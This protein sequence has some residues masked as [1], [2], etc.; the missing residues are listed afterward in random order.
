MSFFS[1]RLPINRCALLFIS[2]F[3][4]VSAQVSFSQVHINELLTSTSETLQDGTPLE[5]I[6]LHNAG[7]TSVDLTGYSLSD[8]LLIPYK[9]L[10]PSVTLQPDEYLLIYAT[11]LN[12]YNQDEYHTNFR[13]DRDGETISLTAPNGVLEDRVS[14]PVQQRDISYGRDPQT[15]TLWRFFSPPSPGEANSPNGLTGFTQPEAAS[16]Q[17]GRYDSGFSLQLLPSNP[18]ADIRYTLDGSDPTQTSALYNNPISINQTTV[19]RT[20]SYLDGYLPSDI[21]SRSYIIRESI[22][23]PILSLSTDPDNLWDSRTGIYANATASGDAWERPVHMEYFA[24]MGTLLSSEDAGIRMHGGASRNRAEKK[25]FRLY[26][27]SDYGPGRLDAPIIPDALDAKPFD[28]LVLRAGYNDS[29]IHWSPVERDLTTYVYDQL[30]R[31]LSGD[32]GAPYS[33]GD[34][35]DLY[36]NGE[37]WGFYNISERVEAD[38][39]EP[40]YGTDEWIVV[41]DEETAEGDPRAWS[42]LRSF[43]QR[44]NF[45]DDDDYLQIQQMVDLEQLTDYYILNIWVSNT[46]WPTKNFYAAREAHEN[47]LWRFIIWDIEWSFGAGGLM[48]DIS[49]N[50]FQNARGNSGT[51]GTMLNRLLRRDEYQQYFLDRLEYNLST[52][53]SEEHVNQRFDELLARVR[54]FMPRESERWDPSRNLETFDSAIAAGKN[55]IDKRTDIVRNHI[56]GYLN[57]PTPTPTPVG[58]QPTPT[59]GGPPTATPTPSPTNPP[60]PTPT[61]TIPIVANLGIFDGNSDIGNVDADGQASY[62][63]ETDLYRVSGSGA[64]VWG[65]EDEFHFVFKQVEGP[66]VFDA[67]TDAINHGSNDWAKVMLMARNSLDPGAENFAIRIR[68]SIMEIS[69]QWRFTQGDTSFSTPGDDRVPSNRHDGRLRIVRENDLFQSYYFDTVD[70]EWVLIDEVSIPMN[71]TIYV[72]FA[73]TSHEDGSLAE[74]VY[75]SVRLEYDAPVSDWIMY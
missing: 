35:A 37:Y 49:A 25:S 54:A 7:D 1:L 51:L 2:I 50:A 3:L 21:T 9:W 16:H 73:V 41:K 53:L 13:L 55:F 60:V 39:F 19:I 22:N 48:G 40:F 12:L 4:T 70:A 6:E 27:R 42:T 56:Y 63:S 33:R 44:A 29:W 5:W 38:M 52:V 66:F 58:N 62:V 64:D 31:N 32:M 59:P 15:T 26:F 17:P 65:V 18:D 46:D 24:S 34:F 71:S 8:E 67:Q 69:S 43:L 11:G 57:E 30:C 47:G 74:G 61:P 10:L 28:K 14:Y 72:G 75:R 20:R 68:E 36:L 23:R 45:S